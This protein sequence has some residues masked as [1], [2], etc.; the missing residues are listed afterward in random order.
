MQLSLIKRPKLSHIVLQHNWDIVLLEQNDIT[1]LEELQLLQL[2]PRSVF[3][4]QDWEWT[5]LSAAFV[6][7][8]EIPREGSEGMTFNCMCTAG[9][10][11]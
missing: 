11:R 7:S 2:P 9:L 5:L 4:V 8:A 1:H 10:V 6:S 3:C